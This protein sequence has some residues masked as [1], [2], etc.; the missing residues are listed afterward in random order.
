MTPRLADISIKK[1]KA[2]RTAYL[3]LRLIDPASRRD[4]TGGILTDGET[5]VD[6]GPQVTH[7]SIPP[8]ATVID[9]RGLIAA[10]GLVDL[11]AH[12]REPGFEHQET[13]H[14]ASRS[15]AVGGVTSIACMPTTR[16]T[17]DDVSLVHFIERRARETSLVKV[18]PVAAVTQGRKGTQ[19]TELGLLGEAGALAF[20]DGPRP[21][22]NANVMRR[23][24]SY[25]TVFDALIM[26]HAED[27]H[28][29]GDGV[30]NSGE[31]ATRLGLEGMAPE[32][33]TIMI[34]RDIRLVEMTGGRLHFS[35]I[36]TAESADLV[37]QARAR[38]LPVS[39]DTAPH[40][41]VLNESAVG[42][43]LTFTKVRPPLRGEEDRQ[44]LVAALAEGV[45]DAVV[46]AHEP[47]DQDSKRQPFA[48]AA[49][50]I[51]GLETL[52]PLVLEI[53]ASG[54]LGLVDALALVTCRPADLLGLKAGRL[55][56]G[57]PADIVLIDPSMTWQIDNHAFQSKSKNS[58]FDGRSVTGRA[59]RTV[60][61]GRT[62]MDIAS[63]S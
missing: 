24:L 27:L 37:R 56:V 11:R 57:G 54:R 25:G 34:A 46:S 32:A 22:M 10:P 38:G 5:I 40:Y 28:L 47:R 26:H 39:A 8:G 12:L 50:G 44:A 2:E 13:I 42:D 53:V 41:L 58:P 23:A 15:A 48:Q 63:T 45:I 6:L 18:H 36:T 14:T 49:F 59:V 43:Y 61:S 29:T 62:V 9:A 4:E 55:E 21:I 19:L 33:E 17:I 1:R 51:V 31:T 7:E 20:S 3:D 60:V 35:S 52:L 16:P 30:M